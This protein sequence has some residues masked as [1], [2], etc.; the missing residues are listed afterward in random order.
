MSTV[1]YSKVESFKKLQKV[2]YGE[3]ARQSTASARKSVKI[4]REH[5]KSGKQSA[6]ES[7]ITRTQPSIKKLTQVYSRYPCEKALMERVFVKSG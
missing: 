1:N 7:V 4:A 3:S 6:E 2:Q 5:V